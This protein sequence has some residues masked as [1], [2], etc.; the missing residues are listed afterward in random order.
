[1]EADNSDESL[2][3]YK[4]QLLGAA[5]KGK[6]GSGE[7]VVIEE[8]DFVF[9]DGSPTQCLKLATKEDRANADKIPLK[10]KEGI[11]YRMVVKFS[12]NGEIVPL[13]TFKN[14][15]KSKIKS[16]ESELVLGS[17]G[18]GKDHTFKCPRYGWQEA[19]SGYFLRG[20]Y[21]CIMQF[22]DGDGKKYLDVP[23]K[24]NIHS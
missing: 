17:F 4:E 1:L 3:K 11:K 9:E 16:Q 24:I 8:F 6:V 23:Y 5:A 14:T 13:L 2:K 19:P 12:V 7:R 22:V 18:P 15:V 20:T 21:Q 10:I